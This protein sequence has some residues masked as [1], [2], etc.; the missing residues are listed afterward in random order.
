MGSG[1]LKINLQT[2]KL[3]EPVPA[4]PGDLPT[5]RPFLYVRFRVSS[6]LV[7][8]L[9]VCFSSRLHRVG[10]DVGLYWRHPRVLGSRGD[11]GPDSPAGVS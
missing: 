8:G 7:M 9:I 6:G 3:A 10:W 11:P 4:L 5:W 2:T 1:Y